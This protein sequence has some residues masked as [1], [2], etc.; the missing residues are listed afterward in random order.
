MF[1]TDQPL[2]YNN[3]VWGRKGY[4]VP[5]FGND[6]TTL[7]E[8]IHQ[9]VSVT[10]RNLS[11]IMHSTDADL[12]TPPSI[13]TIARIH[14]LI[15]RARQIVGS[16]AKAPGEFNME[17]DHSAPAPQ[18]HIIFPVPYFKVRSPHL[19]RYCGFILAALAEAMQHTENRRPI[20]IS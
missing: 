3:G 17:P 19:K 15:V 10:G 6:P 12:R 8:T 4:A 7:N 1:K 20:E 13:N 5:N 18:V 11:A 9:L 16:R 2:W 14:K